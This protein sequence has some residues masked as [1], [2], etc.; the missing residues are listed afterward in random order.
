MRHVHRAGEKIFVDYSG[1]KPCIFDRATGEKRPVELFVA[2]L[3]DM[4]NCCG[5]PA[6]GQAASFA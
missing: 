3:G 2:I 5:S 4:P 1:K 6:A